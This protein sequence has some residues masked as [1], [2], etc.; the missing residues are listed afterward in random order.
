MRDRIR[1]TADEQSAFLA[2][3]NK[4][5]LATIGPDGMPHQVTMYYA[6]FDGRL[7]FWTYASSQKARNLARD[8]RCSILIETGE[9]YENLHGVTFSGGVEIIEDADDVF[10]IGQAVYGRYVDFDV[11]EGFMLDFLRGQAIK[12]NAYLVSPGDVASWDH[13]KLSQDH[14]GSPA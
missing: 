6:M 3:P 12:R 2:L 10:P 5:S 9:G 4:M 14:G 8:P 11:T 1:M 7:G 13:R